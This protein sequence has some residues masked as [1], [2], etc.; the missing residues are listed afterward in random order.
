MENPEDQCD[1]TGCASV[2]SL[3]GVA[4]TVMIISRALGYVIV[5]ES[6]CGF[7]D[8]SECFSPWF[9]GNTLA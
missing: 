4:S 2:R 5:S 1:S 8:G 3:T 7:E 9:T 6:E